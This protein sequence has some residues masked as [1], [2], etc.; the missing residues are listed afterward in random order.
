M[1]E[2]KVLGMRRTLASVPVGKLSLDGT[3]ALRHKQARR[4]PAL[5]GSKCPVILLAENREST[6]VALKNVLE[7]TGY[8]VIDVERA[9]E[10]LSIGVTYDRHIDFLITEVAFPGIN[11]GLL[12]HLFQC[13]HPET[14]ALFLSGSP[15]EVLI[16]AERDPKLD[17]K[18]AVLEQP[19]RLDVFANKVSE[20]I[21]T[22]QG[23]Q[24]KQ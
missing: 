6:R 14:R 4:P 22:R 15:E 9:S 20:M 11:G 13:V 7:A 19:V 12:A 1:S 17:Q 18:I 8:D 2:K 5:A 21:E 10:A 16:W 23:I 3:V 24:Q